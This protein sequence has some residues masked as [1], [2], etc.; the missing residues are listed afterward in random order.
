M[1]QL[2]EQG[3]EPKFLGQRLLWRRNAGPWVALIGTVAI[4]VMFEHESELRQKKSHKSASNMS[5][6]LTMDILDNDVLLNIYFSEPW[7]LTTLP[8]LS[9]EIGL[10][11]CA[12]GTPN[13]S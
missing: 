9:P 8:A 10:Q 12:S 13:W 7:P 11:N 2:L 6:T 5:L 3:P 1:E 4:T